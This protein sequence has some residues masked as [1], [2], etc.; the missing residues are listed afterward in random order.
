MKRIIALIISLCLATSS[1]VDANETTAPFAVP[2]PGT[3]FLS[4]DVYDSAEPVNRK[5]M[6]VCMIYPPF[7][8][9]FTDFWKGTL[10]GTSAHHW[11][12]GNFTET[13][14]PP[15]RKRTSFAFCK[16]LNIRQINLLPLHSK[17]RRKA[18]Y[19][20][21]LDNNL[22]PAHHPDTVAKGVSDFYEF[23]KNDYFE[24][25][26]LDLAYGVWDEP[27]FPQ[28]GAWEPEDMA[29]YVMDISRALR[30]LN[31]QI[32]IALPLHLGD[33]EWNR[34][35]MQTIARENI[36]LI[37]F[38]KFHPF[39]FTWIGAQ[40]KMGSYYARVSA[41]ERQRTAIRKQVQAAF[42]LGQGRWPM[43]AAAWVIHSEDYRYDFYTTTDM[44]AAINIA[45]MFGVFWE[46]NVAS[47]QYFQL[48]GRGDGHFSLAAQTD[49]G[50]RM[51]PT[52]HVFSLYGNYFRGDRVNTSLEAP[53]Y[54]YP[55]ADIQVPV[56]IAHAA[57]D[58]EN[59]RL[60]L[61]L[62]NR[63]LSE[64]APMEV[65]VDRFRPAD[66]ATLI[67]LTAQGD[68]LLEPH[69]SSETL[70]L[71]RGADPAFTVVLPPH[72]VNVLLLKGEKTVSGHDL[73]DGQ[74]HFV[75]EWR[76]EEVSRLPEGKAADD[77][78]ST[79]PASEPDTAVTLHADS[80]GFVN[81]ASMLELTGQIH[82]LERGFQSRSRCWVFS[83]VER[84][85]E[86]SFGVHARGKVLLNGTEIV[87]V[88]S[89]TYSPDPDTHRSNVLLNAGWN[90]LEAR[91]ISDAR[92][93]GFWT[94][95]EQ[96]GDL[97]FSAAA[98]KPD[99]PE[100][101]C[102]VAERATYVNSAAGLRDQSLWK[103]D[104]LE[105][106]DTPGITRRAFIAWPKMTL[107]EELEKHDLTCRIVLVR[108]YR[109]G[110]GKVW[111]RPITEDW[112]MSTV[113]FNR[114]PSLGEV[115]PMQ[116]N[117]EQKKWVFASPQIREL[118]LGWISGNNHGVAVE[119]DVSRYAA[120]ESAPRI[121]FTWRD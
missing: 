121:E 70:T 29:R 100:E 54:R 83:P 6:G 17:I 40:K 81:L 73:F 95:I 92:G 62:T 98:Q 28:K 79:L 69:V 2:S 45:G 107:P 88:T 1:D 21:E 35:A 97:Q 41:A 49:E 117:V 42:E 14:M 96:T 10:D 66:A 85:L 102:V 38:V 31:P 12:N 26:Y 20:S 77:L 50:I 109:K 37:D 89:K 25:E 56:I 104:S 68:K 106:S 18:R 113:S 53:S 51:N 80:G 78:K 75:K 64:A 74:M 46:E 111:L 55:D 72:S 33:V 94:A 114:Q 32:K 58:E 4:M 16:H 3:S 76:V 84:E 115:V 39:D 61:F 15:A 110:E 120:F 93:M 105:L 103:R 116:Q 48:R 8:E 13:A 67:T 24:N 71:P 91:V 101:W 90:L 99:W 34:R 9:T 118:I 108:A 44:A 36:E 60:A 87:A 7:D 22:E 11:M 119:S 57:Y 43:V 82:Q 63:H 59:K 27:Q 52:G 23:V 5:V 65:R 19:V 30:A 47:A 112:E 86:L